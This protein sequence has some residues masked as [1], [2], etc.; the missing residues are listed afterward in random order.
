MGC[1]LLVAAVAVVMFFTIVLLNTRTLGA[2]LSAMPPP[3]CVET[4]FTTML[5]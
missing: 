3:S 1:P 2:S 4:L 5:L